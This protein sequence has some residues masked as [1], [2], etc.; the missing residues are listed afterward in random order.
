MPTESLPRLSMYIGGAW[1]SPASGQYLETVDPFTAKPWALVPRGNAEDADRAG[2]A[3]HHAF[4]QGPWR[5]MHP[6]ACAGADPAFADL[7]EETP[8]SWPRSRCATMAACSPRCATRS[9]MSALVPLLRRPRRQDRG[10]GPSLRQ[11]GAELLAPRAARR[12]RRHRAL[13][14]AAVACRSRRRRRW[15]PAT[16]W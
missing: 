1:V 10:R 7:I 3:P 13:E 8:M 9:A 2:A 14:R 11:A 15:P 12:L 4:K 6:S 5:K 16:R